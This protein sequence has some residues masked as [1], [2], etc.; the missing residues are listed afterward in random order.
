MTVSENVEE[1]G[2]VREYFRKPGVAAVEILHGRVKIGD[3]V[4]FL[5]YT[6]DLVQVIG[7]MQM[8]HADILEAAKGDFVGILVDERVR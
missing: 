5:G 8:N 6:T 3:R 4:R 2:V 1:L 7:S